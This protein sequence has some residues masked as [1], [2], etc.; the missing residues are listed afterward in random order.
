MA[1]FCTKCGKPLVDG[2]PC[3]CEKNE[4]QNEVEQVSFNANGL[5]ETIKGM[6]TRPVSTLQEFVQDHNLV[7]ALILLG[8]NALIVSLFVCLGA[9]EIISAIAGSVSSL[10]LTMGGVEIP[11]ARIF[12]TTLVVIIIVYA[13]LAGLFYLIA[14]K[15]FKGSSSY[16]KMLALLGGT[17]VIMSVTLLLSIVFMYV[18]SQVMTIIF[19]C[20]AIVQ[21]TYMVQGFIYASDID[22]DKV[23]YTYAIVYAIFLTITVFILPQI[24]G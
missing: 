22:D 6:F 9:K 2:K 21:S 8:I 18:S 11:Y 14:D 7:P 3:D 10:L 12:F 15:L 24:L 5:L 19:C 17:S 20:G 4:N 16:K 1:K 13:A 23:G